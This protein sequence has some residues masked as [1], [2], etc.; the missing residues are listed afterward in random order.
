MMKQIRH[1]L[2]GVFVMLTCLLMLGTQPVMADEGQGLNEAGDIHN[3]AQE[4]ADTADQFIIGR[5]VRMRSSAGASEENVIGEYKFGEPVQVV[6]EL[7]EWLQVNVTTNAIIREASP[8]FVHRDFVGGW[9]QVENKMK[10]TSPYMIELNRLG[11]VIFCISCNN[12]DQARSEKERA[13]KLDEINYYRNK[14]PGIHAYIAGSG[15]PQAT[16]NE[17]LEVLEIQKD[18]LNV[19]EKRLDKPEAG[20][21]SAGLFEMMYSSLKKLN[22]EFL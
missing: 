17:M 7:G 22:E 15:L 10:V 21:A 6:A 14:I 16:V 2:A 1:F 5:N 13:V 12:S 11:E 3:A 20:E 18:L 4:F 19:L 9:E 8:R